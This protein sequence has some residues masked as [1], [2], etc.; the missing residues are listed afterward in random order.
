MIFHEQD[1]VENLRVEDGVLANA[2]HLQQYITQC[3]TGCT[4]INPKRKKKV[5][6]KR[7]V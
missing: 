1:I 4:N 6:R 5:Q 3:V 2:C 7:G